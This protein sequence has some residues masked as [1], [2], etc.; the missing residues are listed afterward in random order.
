MTTTNTLEILGPENTDS[1]D[2]LTAL[3][4]LSKVNLDLHIRVAAAE[5]NKANLEFNNARYRHGALSIDNSTL[6]EF[7]LK[8]SQSFLQLLTRLLSTQHSRG[9]LCASSTADTLFPKL[10]SMQLQSQQISQV[11][12]SSYS[13]PSYPTDIAGPLPAPFALTITSIWTQL[14]SLYELI[15]EYIT[16]RIERISIDPI[17]P[18]PGLIFDGVPLENPCTQGMLFSEAIVHLLERIECALGI[19]S[20]PY[21]SQ[22]GLLSA[23][24]IKVL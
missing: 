11:N 15:L 10:L 22:V 7:M 8:A 2:A 12:P 24:Q 23:R 1:I 16:A 6:A 4:E 14:I 5:I 20:G 21:A 19:K 9:V 17:A 13:P 18:I 3:I